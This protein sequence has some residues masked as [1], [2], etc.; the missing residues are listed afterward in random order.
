[1]EI[2]TVNIRFKTLAPTE[3]L[4]LDNFKYVTVTVSGGTC[5]LE[6]NVL[7][8]AEQLI[9]I[10]GDNWTTGTDGGVSFKYLKIT[11]SAGATVRI[12]YHA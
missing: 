11:A 2:T 3:F 8:N 10:E 4:E 5:T 7:P 12:Q 9:L 1:M 6:N